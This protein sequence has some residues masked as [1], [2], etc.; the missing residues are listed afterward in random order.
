MKTLPGSPHP[1]GATWDGQGVNFSLFSASAEGVELCLFDEQGTETRI[2]VTQSTAFVWHVYV[3]GVTVGQRYGYRV[4]GPYDPG[5]GHRF[6]PNVVLLDPYARALDG[7]ERWD[8]GC[9][10]YELGHPDA[11]LHPSTESALGAP[12]GLVIDPTFDWEGDQAP[13]V[14]MRRAVIYEAHVKGLTRLHP[15]V[16]EALRGTYAGMAHPAIVRHLQELGV[17]TIE[18]MPVHAF[19]DD[20]HLL[21]RGLRNYW[22]YNSIG[23]FAPDVRYRSGT[24][25]G[26]EVREFKQMVKDLHRAGLEVILDVVY[27]H[28][29]EGNHLGPTFSFKG[30]DN[31]TYY[32]LVGDD[33]RHYFDYTGTGNTLNVRSPQVLTLIMDSL[34]YWAGEMRVDGF[35]FDLASTLARQLHEVDQLSSFFTLIHQSSTLRELKL[36]AEPWDVGDG[37]YQVGKFPVRWAEWNGRYRDTARAFW[38]GDPGLLGDMG[39]RLTGSSDLYESGG[40]V[41][42]AS[43]NFV[44]AHDGFTLRDLVSYDHKHNEANGEGNRDGNDDERSHGYGA[45]GPSDDPATRAVRA[46]QQRNLLATLLLAQG[47]PML[48]AGDELGRTQQGNNN[49]YCQDNEVSYVDWRLDAEQRALLE[50]T[51]R[52]IRIRREH[53][54]LRRSKFFQGLDVAG[55]ELCDLLWFGADGRPMTEADWQDPET[56]TVQMFL[57]GRGIDDVDDDGRPLVDDNLLL[58]INAADST[59]EVALPELGSVREPWEILVDTSED[60]KRGRLPRELNRLQMVARSTALL[61]APSRVIRQNGARHRLGATYRLQLR[62]EFDLARA[63]DVV[64]YLHDLGVTDVYTSPIMAAATGSS[65]GYDVVDHRHLNPE[66]GGEAA[67]ERFS[68]NLRERGMGLLLDWVPNHM[69]VAVGE[70]RLWDDVLESGKSS[71]Y[72]DFFDIDWRPLREDLTDRVLLPLLGEQYG[73]VLERGELR[74]VWAETGFKLAYYDRLLP[75]ELKSLLPLFELSLSRLALEERDSIRQ[76]FESL[77]SAIRHLPPHHE[78][79]PEL[80]RERSR[81]REV[82][83]RRL[84]ALWGGSPAVRDAFEQALAQINGTAGASSSFDE[85]DRL[86]EQQSYRL[87]CWKVAT[88]EINYRRFFD[89]NELA[90]VRME[91]DEV[92]QET[93]ATLLQLIDAGQV[94]ALRLDHTD[95]LYDPCAYFEKL[96]ARFHRTD[97]EGAISPDDAARPLPILVEKI[98]QRDE[99]LPEEWPIDGTTGYE[100][101]VKLRG[102]WVDPAAEQQLTRAYVSFT[103]DTRSFAEHEYECK[104]HVV[105]YVLISEVNVLAQAA[106]RI[107][108]ENRHSR[109]LTL[110]G[111]TGALTEIVCALPVYRTYL[112]PDRPVPARAQRIVRAAVRLSRLRNPAQSPLLYDFLSDLLLLGLPGNEKQRQG[113]VRFALRFQQLT[114]PIMAKAVE[115]TAFYRYSRLICRNEVGDSPAKFSTSPRELHEENESRARTWPLS[116]A[117]TSTHDSKRGEDAAARIAV[118]SEVP[119]LWQR[120]VKR[121][122]EITSSLRRIIDERPAPEAALEYL[123]YQTLVGVWPFGGGSGAPGDLPNRASEFLLKAAREA[124]TETS[125]LTTNAEYEAAVTAFAEGALRNRIFVDELGRFCAAIDRAGATNALSQTLVRLCVPGVPDT[126][127]GS[128][129]WHQCLVDPDNRRPVDY[130]LRRRYL[131]ELQSKRREPDALTRELVE[132]YPDGRIKQYVIHTV[133]ELRKA[134]PDLFLQ[135]DYV[136]VDSPEHAFAFE[137][138]LAEE[139]ILCVV[140]RFSRRLAPDRSAFPLGAV[141]GDLALRGIA[142]RRYRNLFTNELLEVEPQ[143]DLPLARVFATFPV[144]LLVK[145]PT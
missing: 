60:G 12:R 54:A 48:V 109:D 134:K 116:M 53:P 144:A 33:P 64:G 102:L 20:K 62:R 128:E 14:P 21:D 27:N 145:E 119:E 98:L 36:I 11:D 126:Y 133:L 100:L 95:G 37:G 45:E 137:R 63:A 120:T 94:N 96:Q 140:P 110:L 114:G 22:G 46:R 76:E 74:L 50:F 81:E 55:T 4:H 29:A 47:T 139:R 2:A 129:L 9:F 26:S 91:D 61:R 72:A 107:A 66:L 80:K 117:T 97:V 24:Q 5:R 19:V 1:L 123:F 125:W 71:L 124:K 65:H 25:L 118:L 105:R 28:T 136:A 42:A 6:N 49:A 43:V 15:D 85:L 82:I 13:R 40:R 87:C 58:V 44:T 69:G 30:I 84:V 143:G 56:R 103:G 34:R 78:T 3:P 41:P 17:T 83:G 131:A 67:F 90:A 88:E 130:D 92:F 141:W 108:M 31:A 127:Q 77:I 35:R 99:R 57:A 70:N 111:L 51:K 68:R 16:P 101:G 121:L 112:R 86:L 135:G 104:R 52:L 32:R 132:S 7:V 138:A 75:I 59:L 73:E 142:A 89:V 8:A 10:A 39:Y 38:R 122:H 23:F 106:H 18:L 79:E 93:H 113:H 115:D